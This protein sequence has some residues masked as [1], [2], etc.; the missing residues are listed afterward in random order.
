MSEQDTSP[1]AGRGVPTAEELAE[2]KRK[3]FRKHDPYRLPELP[4]NAFRP[5]IAGSSKA[6]ANA[7]PRGRAS[8]LDPRLA[9]EEE[10]QHFIEEMRPED[11]DFD[12]PEFHSLP[13]EIQYEIIGDLRIR[14]RQQSHKRLASM[15]QKAPTPLDFSKAQ[16][17]QLSQ[18]NVLTQRLLTVT[19][20]IG[21]SGLQIPVRVASERNREYVLVRNSEADGGG[22][23]LGVRDQGTETAPI[24]VEESPR[25]KPQRARIVDG[26]LRREKRKHGSDSEVEEDEKEEDEDGEVI[27]V[28]FPMDPDLRAS[29]QKEFLDAIARR[30]TPQKAT[31][32]KAYDDVIKANPK[33]KQSVPLFAEDPMEGEDD[34]PEEQNEEEDDF[35][36][37]QV[38]TTQ[39]ITI[40]DEDMNLDGND[41]S[42]APDASS[43]FEEIDIPVPDVAFHA[44]ISETAQ[45]ALKR[46]EEEDRALLAALRASKSDA[47]LHFD[48]AERDAS[49]AE[50]RSTMT[51]PSIKDFESDTESMEEV[52]VKPD[53]KTKLREPFSEVSPFFT[54]KPADSP[55]AK[56]KDYAT[57]PMDNALSAKDFAVAESP[58]LHTNGLLSVEEPLIVSNGLL[59]VPAEQ[60]TPQP[61]RTSDTDKLTTTPIAQAITARASNPPVISRP[62]TPANPMGARAVSSAT[63][64]KNA[65]AH[66]EEAST[67]MPKVGRRKQYVSDGDSTTNAGKQITSA[68]PI[69]PPP[70]KLAATPI[71]KD[72]LLK[73]VSQQVPVSTKSRPVHM[74]QTLQ[75]NDSADGGQECFPSTE[76]A[77]PEVTKESEKTPDRAYMSSPKPDI[78]P[79]SN[80]TPIDNEADMEW[81]A[82]PPPESREPAR[83]IPK[84]LS[85]VQLQDNF[86]RALL[87]ASKEPEEQ[88]LDD[89]LSINGDEDSDDGLSE[90]ERAEHRQ[91]LFAAPPADLEEDEG[92][93]DMN[94]EGDDYA[95]FLSQIK[96]RNLT[97]V[98]QEI[99]NEI[100]TLNQ[101]NKVAMR[102]SEEITHQMIAQ[103]QLMLRLFGIPYITAPMEAEAQ[104]AEL[105]RLDL[106]D[107]VITDDND[108]FLFGGTQCFKNLFND[109]KYV[110]CFIAHDLDRELSLNRDRLIS[111]AYLLGSDYTIGLPGVGPVVAMELMAEFPGPRGLE[112]FKRWWLDVQVGKDDVATQ[113][114][115]RKT[116]VS[117]AGNH[118]YEKALISP[119]IQKKKF[120][121]VIH[122]D[123]SWPN[124]L[125]VRAPQYQPE[126][127]ELIY[128]PGYS[129][130]LTIDQ[131]LRPRT[132][133]SIGVSPI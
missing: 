94:A 69:I 75:H 132:S 109:A 44:V 84:S 122:I 30:H 38:G 86:D 14:S 32:K 54:G 64:N 34:A 118:L 57:Q 3:N 70:R 73:N 99:D 16:I 45:E 53:R 106:V 98:R 62:T 55:E 121:N 29:R 113:S 128:P 25:K 11:L 110:E 6:G 42:G 131:R 46:R 37:V 124:P 52:P 100:R 31:G 79:T 107:G 23:V 82:S 74:P 80:I 90:H 129:V 51:D 48:A 67:P 125:V 133:H 36:E 83:A 27:P 104:C 127:P 43:D 12:S 17:A 102:D 112:D 97:E 105:A 120:T 1:F 8:K 91:G 92:G 35:E 50:T 65:D 78:L 130:K 56:S 114:K 24:V 71:R 5:P 96:G 76:T 13:T 63:S 123:P 93:V 60:S 28:P 9:T 10:L 108:V 4:D 115:F 126:P 59:D 81:E 21:N 72:T 95:R 77:Q 18:R 61:K 117:R 47:R 26:V 116:F 40:D 88:A 87:R 33:K 68:D 111:L 66:S 20:S 7:G 39:P 49:I 89:S 15:L 58:T 85:D 41:Q 101:Q 103:I 119:I 22:W 19:D 2:K